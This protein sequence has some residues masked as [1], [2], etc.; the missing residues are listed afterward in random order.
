MDNLPEHVINK[1]NEY[2]PNDKDFKS[3]VSRFVNR[4]IDFYNGD[5]CFDECIKEL[6]L[7]VEGEPFYKY[8][9][10]VNKHEKTNF[11]IF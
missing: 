10:R 5:V 3:P 2:I 7:I 4:L 8:M 11:K 6:Y 9:L 1:I